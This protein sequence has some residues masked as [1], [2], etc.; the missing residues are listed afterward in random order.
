MSQAL[1]ILCSFVCFLWRNQASVAFLHGM[2]LGLCSAAKSCLTLCN[3]MDYSLP[4]S[5]VCGDSPGKNTGV[6]CH[7]LLQVQFSSVHSLSRVRLFATPWTAARQAPL[8]VGIL[9]ARILKWVAMPSSRASSQPRDRTQVSCIDK[10]ILYHLSHCSIG[11][12]QWPPAS[13]TFKF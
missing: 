6:G 8:S 10:W 1:F 3:P 12:C 5:F 11:Y 9:Q 2:G 7:V 13:V 4:G